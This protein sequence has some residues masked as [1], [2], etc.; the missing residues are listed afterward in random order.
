V[1]LARPLL[2]LSKEPTVPVWEQKTVSLITVSR[3]IH[4]IR[5]EGLKILHRH[6]EDFSQNLCKRPRRNPVRA[7]KYREPQHPVFAH[8]SYV[9]VRIQINLRALLL[10]SSSWSMSNFGEHSCAHCSDWPL[11]R[12]LEYLPDHCFAHGFE[13]RH[14]PSFHQPG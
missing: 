10:S 7:E 8:C 9:G 4:I 13:Q 12:S 2:P 5:R 14:R 6:L 11:D 3:P 1:W